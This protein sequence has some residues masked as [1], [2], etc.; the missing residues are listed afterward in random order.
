MK[1]GSG[2]EPRNSTIKQ[3]SKTAVLGVEKSTVAAVLVS[4]LVVVSV[5]VSSVGVAAAKTGSVDSVSVVDGVDKDDDDQYQNFNV[6]VSADA[7]LKGWGM[8]GKGDP[9]FII[10]ATGDVNGETRTRVLKKKGDIENT[11]GTFSFVVRKSELSD[12]SSG[13]IR[14]TATLYDDEALGKKEVDSK[15]TVVGYEKKKYDKGQLAQTVDRIT[16]FSLLY[17]RQYNKRLNISHWEDE[18]ASRVAASFDAMVPTS[19]RDVIKGSAEDL[20]TSKLGVGFVSSLEQAPS[21]VSNT[22]ASLAASKRTAVLRNGDQ[23]SDDYERFRTSLKNLV[24][25]TNKIKSSSDPDNTT[26]LLE[27]RKQILKNV[28]KN[29]KGLNRNLRET[30]DDDHQFEV[31]LI[32]LLYGSDEKSYKLVRADINRLQKYLIVDYAFTREY[33]NPKGVEKNLSEVSGYQEPSYPKPRVTDFSVPDRVQANEPYEVEVTVENRGSDAPYQTVTLGFPDVE[34]ASQIEIVDQ[35]LPNAD[36]AEV[37]GV[38]EKVGAQYGVSQTS[39]DY[40]FAEVGGSWRAGEKHTITVRVT[41]QD[42]GELRTYVKSLAR[43]GG[44]NADP[45]RDDSQKDRVVIDQQSELSLVKETMVESKAE[46]KP[47]VARISTNSEAIE[48]GDKLSLDASNS[49]DPDGKNTGLSY[50]WSV[51]EAPAGASLSA[52]MGPKGSVQL[53]ETGKYV[54]EVAVS[55]GKSSSSATA[56]VRVTEKSTPTPVDTP[57]STP[58]DIPTDMPTT[59]STNTPTST[60]TITSTPTDTVTVTST[61]AS[62]GD[63]SESDRLQSPFTEEFTSGLNGWTVNLPSEWAPRA[64]EG[65]GSWS[66]KH[67]GSIRLHVAGGPSHIGVHR[68]LGEVKKGS[69]IT[70]NYESTNLEGSPG[71]PRILLHLPE[72]DKTP[73]LDMDEGQ[74]DSTRNGTLVGTVPQNLPAGTEL[75]IRLGVWPGEITAYITDIALKSPSDTSSAD[76]NNT[77]REDPNNNTDT[78]R[79]DSNNRNHL[80]IT[81]DEQGISDGEVTYQFSVSGDLKP[82]EKAENGEVHNSASAEGTMGPTSGTDDFYFTGEITGFELQGDAVVYLDGDQVDPSKLAAG[83]DGS[84]ETGQG[85]NGTDGDSSSPEG[86]NYLRVTKDAQGVSDGR[87][88]YQFQV[89]DSL[90][91]GAKAESGEVTD[92]TSAKGS[93][94]PTSGTDDFYFT[95]EITGFELQGDAVVYLNG[96]QIDPSTIA[97]V[98]KSS[99][100]SQTPTI[101]GGNS[102]NSDQSGEDVDIEANGSGEGIDVSVDG[103]GFG[104]PASIAALLIVAY[105]FIRR[106]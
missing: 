100:S 67:G 105:F 64:S 3:S 99:K 13:D 66:E 73:R 49:D 77:S 69:R 94:G 62:G 42:S 7:T 9:L 102:E 72:S 65:D 83:T 57:T 88:Q 70:V 29:S 31:D 24:E 89:S 22:G 37:Y 85:E 15:S 75:E 52:P 36:Y 6:A 43:D 104:F 30:Y 10:R 98:K 50:R 12:F 25:N 19:A 82:G 20:V 4:V 51:E 59:T 1:S 47:P 95:G 80:R 61:T 39:A 23:A 74:S 53:S 35:G 92:A 32:T 18:Q 63:R 96:E 78:N 56:T 2:I 28:Y 55:D 106:T 58:T 90:R 84:G 14:V 8:F 41:P 16:G 17:E 93:M 34:D 26:K 86:E 76:S 87:V 79:N 68:E 48:A 11:R 5:S 27:N 45:S 33:T 101:D 44:W 97:D 71:G 103:P 21:V 54:F 40:P 81:K 91:S 46:N 38:G 60:T